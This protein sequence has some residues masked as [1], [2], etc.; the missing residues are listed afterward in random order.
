VRDTSDHSVGGWDD[1]IAAQAAPL[2]SLLVDAALG[3][4][5]RFLPDSSTAKLAIGLARRPR[6]TTRRLTGL[7]AEVSRAALGISTIE[8][9]QRDRRFADPAWRDN[10]L[11]RRIVQAYL[12]TGQTVEQ[13]IGDAELDWRDDKRARF[14]AENIL[15]AAAPS[16]VPLVNPASARAMIDTGG[17]N[18]VRGAQNFV[19][20]MAA[21]PRVPQ[22]VDADTFEVGHTVAATPGAVVYRTELFE[23]L[24]YEP[25]TKK[26][27]EVPLLVVPP[28]INK[29]YALDLAPGRSLVEH[30]VQAGQQV[31][32]ISWRN[33]DGRH[34][35]WGFDAYVGAVIEALDVVEQVTGSYRAALTGVCSGGILASI[36]AAHIA[37]TGKQERLAA[38]ILLVTVLD[39]TRAGTTSALIDD[40]L[41][42]IAKA[43]SRR[44][45]YL[46]GR[47]LAEVFAWLRPADLVWNYWVNN[48]LLGKKPP[49]FDILFWNNDTTRMPATLHANFVDL[50]MLNQLAAV[51]TLTV[52]GTDID[53]AQV[54]VDSYIVAGV[55]DHITPWES[56]YGTTRL[57]GGE[58]RFVLSTSGHIA[59]LVNPPTNPK[60][61]FQVNK[62]NPPTAQEWLR[63]ADM[64]E[65]SWWPDL[66]EWLDERCA[67]QRPAPK[68]L[69]GGGLQPLEAAPGTY[70]CDK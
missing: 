45:G 33:P 37:A 34:A 51:G 9:S 16:N 42:E 54:T 39:N 52:L 65:G 61:T 10:F 64:R 58:C 24:Q 3:P 57:L 68:R 31:F 6:T 17:A 7:A 11:L 23:L 30:L 62:D 20:D 22:M 53:V 25:Q 26:V 14:F 63:G 35:E 66:V 18:F 41:A 2:D 21:S 19:Q 49:A 44:R 4:I 15:E 60:A 29:Y 32:M 12:A 69:G 50:A 55:A 43:R 40:R 59:A 28:T 27:R 47:S 56:C 36:A 70:V 5:R 38:F 8:P 46:D 1:D 67:E 13:L 48:Y